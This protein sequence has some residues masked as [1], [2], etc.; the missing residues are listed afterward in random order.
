MLDIPMYN[1][2]ASFDEQ[3]MKL[4]FIV[5]DLLNSV[6]IKKYLDDNQTSYQSWTK[7]ITHFQLVIQA[8]CYDEQEDFIKRLRSVRD[9][10]HCVHQKWSDYERWLSYFAIIDSDYIQSF[11]NILAESSSQL[12]K[13]EERLYT[14]N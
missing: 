11:K 5:W 10:R 2:Q 1:T 9:L 7:W 13:L 14:L 8:L 4:G 6:D 12:E 3:C